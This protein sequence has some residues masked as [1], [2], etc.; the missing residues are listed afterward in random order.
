MPRSLLL[1]DKDPVVSGRINGFD[2]KRN[3]SQRIYCTYLSH[4]P[5]LRTLCFHISPHPFADVYISIGVTNSQET[6]SQ[7]LLS[8]SGLFLAL[9]GRKGQGWIGK[10]GYCRWSIVDESA[11]MNRERSRLSFPIHGTVVGVQNFFSAECLIENVT[12][13]GDSF[14]R[15]FKNV[16]S[17]NSPFFN[18]V[19]P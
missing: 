3:S 10:R 16:S 5:G 11:A 12:D 4:H 8:R 1:K 14:R 17:P 15:L 6:E 18:H 2:Q 9:H 7:W 19:V 13:S